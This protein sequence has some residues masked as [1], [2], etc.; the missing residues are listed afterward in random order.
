MKH[1]KPFGRAPSELFWM[2][3]LIATIKFEMVMASSNVDSR[4]R[5]QQKPKEKLGPK[6][7]LN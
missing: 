6:K 2:R 1:F 5:L 3:N 7:S 4:W